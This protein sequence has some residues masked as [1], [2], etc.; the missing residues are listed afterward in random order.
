MEETGSE[1]PTSAIVVQDRSSLS[2][3]NTADMEILAKL[4]EKLRFIEQKKVSV[5]D[6]TYYLA[7]DHISVANATALESAIKKVADLA[8]N[9]KNRVAYLYPMLVSHHSKPAFQLF[10]F[11]PPKS[12]KLLSTPTAFSPSTSPQISAIC[13]SVWLRGA[14]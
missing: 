8:N 12:K 9:G 6:P 4:D 10:L 14:T 1:V 2:A 13:D 5:N 7:L 11:C 3:P